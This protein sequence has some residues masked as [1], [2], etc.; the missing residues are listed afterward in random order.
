MN[1]YQ[2]IENSILNP[3]AEIENNNI[4]ELDIK[5]KNKIELENDI[6][7]V[8]DLICYYEKNSF[9]EPDLNKYFS[10]LIDITFL[11]FKE[12]NISN[13]DCFWGILPKE[14]DLLYSTLYKV[15]WLNRWAV[16]EKKSYR[17]IILI[18]FIL[19]Y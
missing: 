14:Q 6:V 15:Y 13:F 19:G 7:L 17:L 2:I 11:K 18:I 5:L 4:S 12:Y 8:T 16:N 1:I 3:F 10:W 9:N